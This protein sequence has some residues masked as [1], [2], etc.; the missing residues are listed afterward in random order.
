MSFKEA[1]LPIYFEIER[2]LLTY[3]SGKIYQVTN[4][5]QITSLP[6]LVKISEKIASKRMI[7]FKNLFNLF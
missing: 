6:V 3:K 4:Y 5:R 7:C 2:I 1:N